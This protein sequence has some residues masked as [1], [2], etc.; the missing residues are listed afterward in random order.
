MAYK[1]I[2]GTGISKNKL[3]IKT[4]VHNSRKFLYLNFVAVFFFNSVSRFQNFRKKFEAFSLSYFI[5]IFNDAFPGR[6]QWRPNFHDLEHVLCNFNILEAK[7]NA[8][9]T[10]INCALRVD[11]LISVPLQLL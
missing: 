1:I 2:L 7:D 4:F 9:Y 8:K 10:I 3:F 6:I 5:L 11:I